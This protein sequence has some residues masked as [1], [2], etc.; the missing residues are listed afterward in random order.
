MK[1]KYASGSFRGTLYV[2]GYTI[3]KLHEN[4]VWYI[5]FYYLTDEETQEKKRKKFN[6]PPMKSKRDRRALA[7]Q[8]IADLTQR[9]GQGWRPEEGE[10]YKRSGS[11]LEQALALYGR[12]IE[13]F[14][15]KKSRINYRSRLKNF[16]EFLKSEGSKTL[17]ASDFTTGLI[18]RFL[19]YQQFTKKNQPR[20]LNNYL[21]W[22]SAFGSFMIERDMLK[23]NPASKIHKFPKPDKFRQQIPDSEFPKVCKYLRE[24]DPELYLAA[25]ILY[26]CFIR[27]SE[28]IGLKV[29][30][31][32]LA[33]QEIF[34][35]HKYSKNGK[36]GVVGINKQLG[37]AL[38]E[39]GFLNYPSSWFL[40][41]KNMRPGPDQANSDIFGKRW[42]KHRSKKKWPSCWQFYSLKDTGLNHLGNTAGV[43]IARD[44]A[45]HSDVSTTNIYLG[46]DRLHAPEAA[47]KY[48]ADL[49]ED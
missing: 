23:E 33:K 8:I 6:V 40:F 47:K 44:Q 22:C 31:I 41:S 13:A 26:F 46:R 48:I 24:Q 2:S 28:M 30:D 27:P 5:D 43:V 14:E 37:I 38:L 36:D 19:D 12:A 18:R 21:G 34:V 32:S 35:S 17:Y 3:P 11:T 10:S 29:G 16:R 42:C 7:G 39:S 15:K 20:T 1:K 4:S 9:L 49:G 25:L 45:R